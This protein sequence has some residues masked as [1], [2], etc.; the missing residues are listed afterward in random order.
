ML[1]ITGINSFVGKKLENQCIKKNI[2]YFGV[3]KICKNSKN[4]KS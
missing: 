2:K 4:K 3:D 1:I